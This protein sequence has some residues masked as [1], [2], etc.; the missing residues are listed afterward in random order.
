MELKSIKH[1][2]KIDPKS[3]F[4]L[5]FVSG[6]LKSE[7]MFK[8]SPRGRLVGLFP[9]AGF[10]RILPGTHRGPQG[11][12]Q[13][14]S[15]KVRRLCWEG[16]GEVMSGCLLL[17][18]VALRSMEKIVDLLRKTVKDRQTLT[19]STARRGS[20]DTYFAEQMIIPLSM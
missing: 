2:V 9:S 17:S 10:S 7:K 3:C 18:L 11:G 16:F 13:L 6:G 5:N 19:R 20:A 12:P 4:F 14:T 8:A 15:G 1:L